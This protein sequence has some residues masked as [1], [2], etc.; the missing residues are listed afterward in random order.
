[1]DSCFGL[2]RLRQHGIANTG[3]QDSHERIASD[4]KT[5]HLWDVAKNSQAE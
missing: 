5:V 1:M 4:M 3:A 2:V